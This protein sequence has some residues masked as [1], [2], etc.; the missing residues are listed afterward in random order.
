MP[1]CSNR[2]S[3]QRKTTHWLV[4]CSKVEKANVK[5]R[6]QNEENLRKME[7]MQ[8]K[9]VSPCVVAGL[10]CCVENLWRTLIWSYLS[11][12]RFCDCVLNQAVGAIFCTPWLWA[13]FTNHSLGVACFVSKRLTLLRMYPYWLCRNDCAGNTEQLPCRPGVT[14]HLAFLLLVQG[15]VCVIANII[16]L[17]VTIM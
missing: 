17:R 3:Q 16:G 15:Q 12:M 1:R 14:S 6:K 5:L 4:F 9:L 2:H 11:A 13:L 10:L 8:K 7:A